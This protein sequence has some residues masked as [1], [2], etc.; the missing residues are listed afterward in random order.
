MRARPIHH[1]Q[2]DPATYDARRSGHFE[3]RRVA[4]VSDLIAASGAARVI[5]LGGGTGRI[6]YLVGLEHPD[7]E[8]RVVEID[9]RMIAY[10]AERYRVRRL[11]RATAIPVGFDADLLFSIDVIHHLHDRAKIFTEMHAAAHSGAKWLIIEP[12]ISH[13]YMWWSQESM[14][15]KGLDEDHF[16]PRVSEPEFE[17]AGWRIDTK[18]YMHLWPAAFE[19]SERTKRVERQLEMARWLGGSVVYKLSAV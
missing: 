11:A 18:T 14:R 7:V 10:G 9:D 1:D 8:F 15:R 13:P 12:N 16:R 19:P 6:S 5:E 4:A 17:R 2:T 3:K